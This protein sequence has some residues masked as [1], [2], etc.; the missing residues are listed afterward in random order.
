MPKGESIAHPGDV[1]VRF[2]PAVDASGYT[3]E[4]RNEL[5][6]RVESLVAAGLPTDQQPLPS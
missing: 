4:Q 5:I 1:M 2:G 3:L 6:V